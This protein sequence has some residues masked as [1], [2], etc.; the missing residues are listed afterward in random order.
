MSGQF[1]KGPWVLVVGMHRSGTSAIAGAIGA[2]GMSMPRPEDRISPSPSNPE[3]WESHSIMLHNQDVLDRFGGSWDAP[4]DLPPGWVQ[5]PQLDG[6]PD[7]APL[8]AS[9]FPDPGPLV[10][11]DPRVCLLLPYWRPLLP[12]PVAA[13]FVWR[14]P[15][16]V[17]RSLQKRDGYSLFHGL[18]LWERYN[19]AAL[20]GLR[21]ME[22]YALA[23]E[24]LIQDH[25][26]TVGSVAGWL[27]SLDQFVS[28]AEAWD[29]DRAASLVS[30][31]LVH[32]SIDRGIEDLLLPEHRSMNELL[33][34]LAGGHRQFDPGVLPAE[35]GWIK[36]I[37]AD[38]REVR[39]SIKRESEGWERLADQ[40]RRV[41]TLEDEVAT[42][43]DTVANLGAELAS[44][45]ATLEKAVQLMASMRASTSWRVTKPLRTL[46][47]TAQARLRS[48]RGSTK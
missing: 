21:G 43:E 44:T 5:G 26:R 41:S 14:S 6:L 23:Y 18:S 42:L 35:S 27:G 39:L 25:R 17:A 24:T 37:L 46:G 7:P 36:D 48:G 12:E 38:R 9:T 10:W 34:G 15:V 33:A 19:R 2:L 3:H 45:Q 11:K 28:H 29:V 32:Q 4:P 47:A 31:E 13:V 30:D 16:A 8:F 1:P 20:D 40:V 22:V